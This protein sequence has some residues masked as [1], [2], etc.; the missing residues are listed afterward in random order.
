MTSSSAAASGTGPGA[1]AGDR[2][3]FYAGVACYALWSGLSLL[4]MAMA[5]RGVGP[6]ETLAYR[7]LWALPWAAALVWRAGQGDQA[8]AVLASPRTLMWLACSAAL[9]SVNWAVFIWA[10]TTGRKL[11]ASLAYYINPLLNMAAGAV[12]FRER[13]SRTGA[14]AIALAAAGVALQGFA[15]GHPPWLAL[16]MAV[17]FWAYGVIRKQVTAGAQVGLFVESLML[18]PLGLAYVWWLAA[19]GGAHLGAGWTVT[20][21]ILAAGPA[22]VFPLALFAYA[23]RRLPLSTLGFLQFIMPTLI[24]VIAMLTGERLS[25][26]SA[27]SFVFIW[28]GV[29]VYLGGAW[30]AARRASY[31]KVPSDN[32]LLD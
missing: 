12:L 11:D 4:F 9:V 7:C 30:V 20:A 17:T 19:H 18:A 21:L 8:R 27:V 13:F 28:S 15:V 32:A 5:A 16:S 2:S 6:W 22:T 1:V 29:A 14:A 10:A 3:A 24:F 26:L 25:P 31:T 23:A